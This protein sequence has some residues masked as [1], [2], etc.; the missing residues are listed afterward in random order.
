MI[1][2]LIRNRQLTLAQREEIA[3]WLFILPAVLGVI[4]W[5][6]GPMIYSVWLSM[7]DW[8]LIRPARFVGGQNFVRMVNDPLFYKSLV[9]TVYY[10]AFHVPLTLI[11]AFAVALLLNTKTRGIALFRT[12]YYLPTIVPAVANAVL[13]VWIFNSEFGLLNLLLRAMGLPKILWLQ[14]PQT[15]M[16]ALIIM[17][18]WTLG[19]TMIIFLA[20]LNGISEQLYEAAEIDGAGSWARFWRITI[21]LMT[22]VIFFNLILQIIGS[23]QVFTAGY[24]ITRGGPNYATN[25]YVLYLFDNAFSWFNMGY[26]AA[27]AWVLFVIVLV[28]SLIVFRSGSQWVYYEEGN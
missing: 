6:A 10:T 25:F 26:A 11:L 27:L 18:L 4:I 17:S 22:P 3:G 28:L 13:W 20:G 24:L 8:D 7:T 9:V 15:A 16:P 2:S 21:P 1:T 14:D 5:L 12:L 23:F 19:G